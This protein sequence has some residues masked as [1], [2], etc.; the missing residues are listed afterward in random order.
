MM[1]TMIGNRTTLSIDLETYSSVDLKNCGAYK[2]VDSDDFEV[3]LFGYSIDYGPVKVIDLADGEIFPTELADMLTDPNVLKTAYNAVFERTALAKFIRCP[4]PPEQWSC[5]LVL[6]AQAGLPLGLERVCEAMGLPPDKA[7]ADG[8]ALI[9]YF[10]MPCKPTLAN[11]GRTRNMPWDDYDK[12]GR[13]VEYNRRD[14]EVENLIRRKLLKLTPTETEQRFWCL[15]QKINDAGVRLDRELIDNAIAFNDNYIEGLSQKAYHLSGIKNVKSQT[16][17]KDWLR[18]VEGKNF[19]TL[20]KKAMPDVLASLE[21][22]E[23]K[24]FLALRTELTKTSVAKFNKMNDCACRDD[25]ARGLFQFYGANRTG[26]FSGRL[27]QLQNL[28]QNHLENIADVRALVKAGLYE[29]FSEDHPN[30]ASTLSELIRTAIIP[31]PG[32]QFVVAD[33]SA[34]EAR[35][36]AWFAKEHDDLE[37]FRGAGKIYELTASRMFGVPKEKIAKGNPE[38]ALRA[39]GKVATLACGYGG[40]KGALINMGA[41]NSGIPEEELPMLVKQWRDSHANIVNLWY[42]LESAAKKAIRTKSS[43]KDAIGGV[44]FDF[45]GHNLYMRL[46]SGRRLSYINAQI[47]TN[48]FGKDSIV[49]AGV[50]QETHRWEMLETYGGKLVEN[51]V[52]ATARDCLRDAMLRM[53][54]AGF[55]I[56]MHVHDEVICNEPI[57]GRTLDDLI[58]IMKIPPDWAP[59][60]PLNAAGFTGDFYMKD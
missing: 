50:N 58:A 23:A 47:G 39:K 6:A 14:V 34:I 43:A 56:R 53:D 28:P 31:E 9:R 8:A 30:V 41:L 16:Q 35:V 26:R 57:G 20:N 38:Y 60:L 25:H 2:Y 40:G 59:D 52:Q 3:L 5:T 55:D 12:W 45:E 17:I 11:R 32:C 48:R 29:E 15:D 24:E 10:S 18:K 21:T 27:I 49:Y 4:M 37:E 19:E 54:E 51:L 44:V 33:F 46:P 22:D 13:Y 1:T 36:I 42:S 7:K